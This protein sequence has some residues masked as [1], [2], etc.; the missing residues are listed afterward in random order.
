[1]I[2]RIDPDLNLRRV[3]RLDLLKDAMSGGGDDDIAV[4][5]DLDEEAGAPRRTRL[6]FEY[7]SIRQW[8]VWRE[9]A[10][11]ARES[12]HVVHLLRDIDHA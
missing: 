7:A 6:C 9:L 12:H 11:L 1:M 5:D 2:F 4:I 3:L 8:D 10:D